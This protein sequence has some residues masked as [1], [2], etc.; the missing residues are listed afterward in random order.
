M[1]GMCLGITFSFI[2]VSKILSLN[3]LC[4]SRLLNVSK[5]LLPLLKTTGSVLKHLVQKYVF[6]TLVL[7]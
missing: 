2:L 5:V 4:D 7:P 6:R 3:W 1:M